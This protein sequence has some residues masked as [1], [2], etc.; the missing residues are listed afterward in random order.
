MWKIVTNESSCGILLQH[1][2]CQVIILSKLSFDDAQNVQSSIY[3]TT[4]EHIFK[5]LAKSSQ[6]NVIKFLF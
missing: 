4:F 2:S 1:N 6:F 3:R 5:P